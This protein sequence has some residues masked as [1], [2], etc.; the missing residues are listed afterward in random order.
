MLESSTSQ[1]CCTVW[2]VVH[3]HIFSSLS[4]IV[5][6]LFLLNSWHLE[7]L[8]THFAA[9]VTQKP[10]RLDSWNFTGMLP[11]ISCCAPLYFQFSPP[12]NFGVLVPDLLEF[13][14]TYDKLWATH[15][16]ESNT[17]RVWNFT[18][19][20]PSMNFCAPLCF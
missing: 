13:Y 7:V 15:N 16:S 11:S 18:G 20:L 19:I 10:L 3:L 6:E 8:M 14:I 4:L 5:L 9:R 12:D 17:A 1:E 2:V